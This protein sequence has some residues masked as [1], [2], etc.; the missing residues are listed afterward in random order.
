MIDLTKMTK[1]DVARF[2]SKVD[3]STRVN[4]SWATCWGWKGSHKP[5]GYARFWFQG[6]VVAAHRVAYYLH[7]GSIGAHLDIDHLC[8]TRDCVDPRHLEAVCPEVNQQRR[9][10]ANR[11]NRAESS[12][13]RAGGIP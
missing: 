8:R 12:P 10:E 1:R 2:W 6:H 5:N 11:K 7:Y 13:V 4:V 3:R 9:R